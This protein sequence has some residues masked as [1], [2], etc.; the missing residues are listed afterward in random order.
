[1]LQQ[2]ETIQATPAT[3]SP[4]QDAIFD[5]FA[6]GGDDHLVVRARAGTGKT[7]TI[8]KAIDRAPEGRILLSA[9]NKRIQEELAGRIQNSAAEAKTLHGVGYA[10]VR[11][12][13][14][15]IPIARGNDRER[16]LAQAVCGDQTPDAVKRLVGRLCTKGRE[17]APLAT[18]ADDL[19]DIAIEFDCEPDDAW[20]GLGFGLDYVI[21]RA[22]DAMEL[23]ATKKPIDGIDFADMLYLPVRNHWLVRQYDLCVVDEAQDMTVTQLAIARGVC[24]GRMAVVGDDRQAIYAFRG[25]DSESL[26]RLKTELAAT[27]LG[28]TT[29]YR[30]PSAIVAIAQRLVPDYQSAPGAPV[31]QV[32]SL[33]SIDRLVA[34]AG[35]DD[36]ILSR[37][38]A[39]LAG[40][41]MA[42]IRAQ[43]RVRIQGR[44]IGAGLRS[45]V[46]KLSTGKAVDSI[47]AFL[48]RL[49]RWERREIDRVERMDRPDMAD[50][51][52]DK[53]DTLR[54]IA[55][56]VSGRREL[57]ARLD[58]LF[59]D[60][61]AGATVCSSV[62]KAKGLE[63]RRVFILRPTLYPTPPKGSKPLTPKRIR[64]EQNIEYVAVTRAMDHL[65]W[66][67]AK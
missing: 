49:G 33:P 64:E 47:A 63:A 48:E 12:F 35:P 61:G 39:P 21:A 60:S 26:D 67:D 32:S 50:A 62:H 51:I 8:I 18:K 46:G 17:I 16:A 66:V 34:A 11:R 5:W 55:D 19:I 65:V 1:M 29:T 28:L 53:A 24:G 7:T 45:L 54:V 52:R 57:E 41:A 22:L 13:W 31:G 10:C 40:V 42:M 15:R 38:N 37:T 30:C 59:A 58:T 27:E 3:W 23:A 56:G 6:A 4:Q 25:A 9:F 20:D 44:D 36:F 14:E 43:K 2:A